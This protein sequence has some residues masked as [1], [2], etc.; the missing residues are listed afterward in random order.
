MLSPAAVAPLDDDLQPEDLD[1]PIS[2]RLA[3]KLLVRLDLIAAHPSRVKKA[4]RKDVFNS[5]LTD[6][7]ERWLNE[8]LTPEQRKEFAAAEEKAAAEIRARFER[9]KR[10]AQPQ[11][12]PKK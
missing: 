10:A 12:K 9:E 8:R 2:H 11:K 6:Q 3:K 5:F 1:E 7:A 4:T